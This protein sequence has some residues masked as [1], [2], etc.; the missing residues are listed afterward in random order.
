[1]HYTI[2]SIE[3]SIRIKPLLSKTIGIIDTGYIKK[4][5]V[6]ALLIGAASGLGAIVFYWAVNGATSLMLGKLAGYTPPVPGGEGQTVVSAITRRWMIPVVCTLG[7]LLSGLVLYKLTPEAMGPGT[8]AAIDSFHNKDG[9]IRRRVPFFKMLASAITIGS[10]GSA[11]R[12]GPAALIGGGFG[13]TL[14]DLLRLDTR[15]RRIALAVG[16]GAGMGAIFKAPLGGAI[17]GAEILYRRDFEFEV[18]WPA[19]IASIVGYSIFA[20][21]NGW[22]PIFS[23]TG[24]FTF[25]R[26]AEL[27]G[28]AVLGIL[29]GV[30]GIAYGRSFHGVRI[31]FARWKIPGYVKPAVGGLAVGIIGLFLPQVLGIGYGWLQFAING[32]TAA[33]PIGIMVA[34][35]FGK[36]A[37]TC[38]SIGS[39][40]SG[41]EFAPGLVIGGMLGGITWWALHGLT[42]FVPSNPA[43]YVVL[44]MMTLFGGI[45]KAPLAIIIMVS[46]MTGNY[47]L[48]VPS[49]VAVVI[50]YFLTGD[51]FIYEAQVA[52]RADSPAHRTEY[53]TP[54]MDKI[55]LREAMVKNPATVT[56]DMF[57]SDFVALMAA[58][59]IDAAPVVSHGKLVGIISNLDVARLSEQDWPKL[60]VGD[61]MTTELVV[62]YADETLYDALNRM[63]RNKISHL[64]VVEHGKPQRMVGFLAVHDLTGVYDAQRKMIR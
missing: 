17:L 25:T 39:G 52:S 33:L 57:I 4:W 27:L 12:E 13:S 37:A 40:G 14:A 7:G 55:V 5:L 8:D 3:M 11:G 19:F 56:P 35:L 9:L 54:L 51:N 61:K 49:M 34:V 62:G 59:N 45:A 22:S 2:F 42:A 10:G 32:N 28:Y 38:F 53:S 36:L 44:G 26:P 43:P 31:L 48:L 6:L 29:C 50:A 23:F 41:G 46:E 1:M 24:T 16:V 58:E 15:D 20:S 63:S 47:N 30:A 18:L 64:P 60:H 21:W